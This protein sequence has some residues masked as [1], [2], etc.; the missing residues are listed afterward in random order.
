MTLITYVCAIGAVTIGALVQGAVG[1][2]LGMLAAPILGL[3]DDSLVPGPLLF[4]ALLLTA[5]LAWNERTQLDWPGVKWALVGRVIGTMGAV[6]VVSRL[7]GD[8]LT[9]VLGISILAGVALSLTR[10]SLRPTPVTLTG[11][12]ALS[13]FMGTL[14]SV[15]GP[16]IALVY[17]REQ[18]ARLRS[19]LAGFF[20]FG[21]TLSLSALFVAGRFGRAELEDGLILVPG[22]VLGTLIGRPARPFLDRGW[23]RTCVLG[24][25]A[26]AAATLVIESWP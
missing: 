15:G 18:A 26:L 10:W 2:G 17:Q 13:G 11:A 1:F 5:W 4:L 6:F 20:F 21:A 25:S 8:S 24:L 16:P 23:T 19:T 3:L 7:V 22:L 14:T 12:G 9:L